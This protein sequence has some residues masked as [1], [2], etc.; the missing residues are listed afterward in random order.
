MTPEDRALL[1]A[2]LRQVVD[3]TTAAHL[4]DAVASAEAL[5]KD[6]QEALATFRAVL[7]KKASVLLSSATNE[8]GALRSLA[9]PRPWSREY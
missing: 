4:Q 3:G 8:V 6:D 5:L 1:Q 2:L 7:Q 9:N